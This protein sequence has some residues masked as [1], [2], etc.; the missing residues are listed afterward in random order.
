M[1][2]VLVVVVLTP[3]AEVEVDQ[4]GV[5]GVVGEGQLQRPWLWGALL[6]EGVGQGAADSARHLA[7]L[8]HQLL[9]APPPVLGQLERDGLHL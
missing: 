8:Q 3:D 6:D 2:L 7:I 1:L 5:G 4:D 9:L